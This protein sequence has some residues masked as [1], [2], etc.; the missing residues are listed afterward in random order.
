M[1]M[2]IKNVTHKNVSTN[3]ILRYAILYLLRSLHIFKF[4]YIIIDKQNYRQPDVLGKDY[5]L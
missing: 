2:K 4:Q 3:C 1:K 5:V